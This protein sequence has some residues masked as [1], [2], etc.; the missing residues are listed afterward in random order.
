MIPISAICKI[1]NYTHKQAPFGEGRLMLLQAFI[2]FFVQRR[3]EGEEGSLSS[4][5]KVKI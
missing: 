3:Q 1:Q 2:S 5:I 4:F